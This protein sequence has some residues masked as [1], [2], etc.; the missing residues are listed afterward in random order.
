[1]GK[2][3]QANDFMR[4]NELFQDSPEDYSYFVHGNWLPWLA[5]QRAAGVLKEGKYKVSDNL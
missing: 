3:S 5:K 2:T 4:K 1:M